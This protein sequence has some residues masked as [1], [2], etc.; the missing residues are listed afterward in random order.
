MPAQVCTS[1]CYILLPRAAHRTTRRHAGSASLSRRA[2][3]L[4]SAPKNIACPSA[5]PPHR[6]A[7]SRIHTAC[8]SAPA[9][10]GNLNGLALVGTPKTGQPQLRPRKNHEIIEKREQL[11]AQN[12]K[13]KKRDAR[14]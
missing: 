13:H 1:S 8:L 7:S 12:Q 5:R 2:S 11:P 6:G 14:L 9:D 10:H 3:T 4:I